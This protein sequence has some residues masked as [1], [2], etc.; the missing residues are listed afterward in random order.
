MIANDLLEHIRSH[1]AQPAAHGPDHAR[2]G[3]GYRDRLHAALLMENGSD[4]PSPTFSLP[5]GDQGS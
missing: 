2:H 5:F 1:A 3:M 4:E